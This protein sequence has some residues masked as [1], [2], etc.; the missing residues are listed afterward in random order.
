MSV[1]VRKLTSESGREASVLLGVG[2]Y[3]SNR[4]FFESTGDTENVATGEHD[5]SWFQIIYSSFREL[6]VN[7]I[8]IYR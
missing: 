4:D 6:H 7:Q 1:N 5:L 3:T 8:S 2:S